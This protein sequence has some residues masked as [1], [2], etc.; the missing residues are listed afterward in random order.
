MVSARREREKQ[1]PDDSWPLLQGFVV[2][3]YCND[4]GVR[5]GRLSGISRDG[6][7]DNLFILL[8]CILSLSD[9]LVARKKNYTRRCAYSSNHVFIAGSL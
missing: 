2:I 8:L 3:L 9:T 4:V 5:L 1:L 7:L 6:S